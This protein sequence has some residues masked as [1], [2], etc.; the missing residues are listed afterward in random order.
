MK[1]AETNAK[2]PNKT[3][4]FFLGSFANKAIK[5]IAKTANAQGLTES[6]TASVITAP[7]VNFSFLASSNLHSFTAS[8]GE[9]QHLETGGLKRYECIRKRF[10]SLNDSGQS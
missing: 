10:I 9:S 5:A 2:P 1:T 8:N 6:A 7:N 3:A 4:F